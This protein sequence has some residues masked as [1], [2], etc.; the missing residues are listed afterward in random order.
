MFEERILSKKFQ[1]L[2]LLKGALVERNEQSK[3]VIVRN[4]KETLEELEFILEDFQ[5]ISKN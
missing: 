2:N 1:E 5:Y 3:E 4:I